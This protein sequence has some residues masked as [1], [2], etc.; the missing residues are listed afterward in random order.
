MTKRIFVVDDEAHIRHIVSMKLANAGYDIVT[1]EDGE[2]ALELCQ[3]E[4]P[5]LIITDYQMPYV[6]GLEM[7]HK[8]RA[9]S[10]TRDIPVLML[11]A[12]DFDIEPQ[13]M[14][15][16]GISDVLSKPFSPRE[17]LK[18]V[19]E[20]IGEPETEAVAESS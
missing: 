14:A 18:R 19:Q 6:T 15:A 9:Q 17:V 16:A 12:R 11:T 10:E 13:E 2:E 8:L 1:A 5:D 3:S 20:L 4:K 7:C